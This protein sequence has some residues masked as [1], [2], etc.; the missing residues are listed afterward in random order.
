MDAVA[1]TTRAKT[2]RSSGRKLLYG[3]DVS[4]A[5]VPRPLWGSDE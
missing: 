3:T 5:A 2:K 1:A 4:L